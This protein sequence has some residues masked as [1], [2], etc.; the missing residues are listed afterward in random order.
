MIWRRWKKKANLKIFGQPITPFGP[1]WLDRTLSKIFQLQGDFVPDFRLMDYPVALMS[2]DQSPALDGRIGN[3][4]RLKK[5]LA[6]LGV[7]DPNMAL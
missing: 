4:Q 3:D 7:F 6:D 2:T 1:Q 5:D